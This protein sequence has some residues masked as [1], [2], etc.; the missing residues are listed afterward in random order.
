[1]A[2]QIILNL[3]T[4]TPGTVVLGISDDRKKNIYSLYRF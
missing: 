4:L 3:I 1:M 2:I